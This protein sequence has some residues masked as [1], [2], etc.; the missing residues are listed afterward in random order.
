MFLARRD[1]YKHTCIHTFIPTLPAIC[2]KVK[3]FLTAVII[4]R[5]RA[6]GER[7]LLLLLVVRMVRRKE[8]G[9]GELKAKA[10]VVVMLVV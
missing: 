7:L 2:S 3:G 9:R 1:F 10:L 4:V 5:E 8:K 6:R